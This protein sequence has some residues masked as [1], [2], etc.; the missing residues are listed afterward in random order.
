MYAIGEGVSQDFPA[1][2][3]WFRKAAEQGDM[4]AQY[5]L[6][7]MHAEGRGV[8]QNIEEAFTWYRKAADQGH[9]EAQQFISTFDSL[10]NKQ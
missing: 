1:A 8:P 5:F 9:R 4:E 7:A 2:E 6:G 10:M 3:K